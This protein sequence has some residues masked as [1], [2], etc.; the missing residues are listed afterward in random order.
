LT[1]LPAGP[2][3]LG[4]DC[5]AHVAADVD[6]S[7][8]LTALWTEVPMSG[9]NRLVAANV[10]AGSIT[11]LSTGVVESGFASPAERA[12]IAR[13]VGNR[14]FV[15]LHRY[16]ANAIPQ[17][18][19]TRARVVDMATSGAPTAT[20][21]VLLPASLQLIAALPIV[22]QD[23]TRQVYAFAPGLTAPFPSVSLGMGVGLQIASYA[24]TPFSSLEAGAASD[25]AESVDPRSLLGVRGKLMPTDEVNVFAAETRL[26]DGTSSAP[27]KMSTQ[28][29]VANNSQVNCSDVVG[30]TVQVQVG[31]S[32][33]SYIVPWRQVNAAGT[34]CDLIVSGQR[35]NTGTLSVVDYVVN[36]Y[37][38]AIVAVWTE[39][40]N[41][42]TS[43]R[44]LWSR[45]DAGSTSWSTPAPVAPAVSPAAAEQ[46]LIR[47]A[48]GPSGTVAIVWSTS[49]GGST[50][51][52]GALVSKYAGGAWTTVHVQ[53]ASATDVRA[54]AING[55]GQGAALFRR[56]QCG[57]LVCEELAG[58]RF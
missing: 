23:S 51:T 15:V 1:Q 24:P 13:P 6:A 4:L 57:T 50:V 21:A 10:A 25:F 45:R 53:G 38:G 8:E 33:T 19:P 39:R 37:D 2:C 34:G 56:T 9:A 43:P 54:V 46:Q 31:S 42:P 3:A 16:G 22:V 17:S 41:A 29:V 14:R 11:P 35:V 30:P 44:V 18:E 49:G 36:A 32:G 5:I 58:Y 7:G 55:A 47:M 12:F 28:P 52:G 26:V 48:R 27:V 20:P 40:N